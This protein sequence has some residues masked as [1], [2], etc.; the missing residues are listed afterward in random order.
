MTRAATGTTPSSRRA[1]LLAA[2]YLALDSVNETLPAEGRLAR[3]ES[4][5]ILGAD[6][7]LDSLGFVTLA[8]SVETQVQAAFGDCPSLAEALPALEADEVTLGMLADFL[9]ARL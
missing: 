6:A 1:K 7:K 4:E 9:D 8:V 2:I 3:D 5:R